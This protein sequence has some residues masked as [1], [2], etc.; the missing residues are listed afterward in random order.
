MRKGVV[1]TGVGGIEAR[2]GETGTKRTGH[3]IFG[4][5]SI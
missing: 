4:V 5:T 3:F 1:E 2:W